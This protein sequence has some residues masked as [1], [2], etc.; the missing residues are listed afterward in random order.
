MNAPNPL[1]EPSMSRL[2]LI[3]VLF[4]LGSAGAQVQPQTPLKGTS[5]SR[6]IVELPGD[7]RMGK[8]TVCSE[9]E[10]LVPQL[11]VQLEQFTAGKAT[12]DARVQDLERLLRNVNTMAS[13]MDKRQAELAQSLNRVLGQLSQQPEAAA[14]RQIRRYS[15]DVEEV[16]EKA[17]RTATASGNKEAAAALKPAIEE[18][19]A[20]FD[21]T[22]AGKL[23]DAVAA[24]QE[25]L[26]DVDRKVDVVVGNT[27]DSRNMAVFVEALRSKSRGDLGQVRVL[28]VFVQQGRTFDNQ[29]FSGVGFPKAQVPGL[30]APGANLSLTTFP[31]ADLKGADLSGARMI[32]AVLEG[33]SLQGAK[34]P[35]ARAALVQAQ[36]ADLQGADLSRSNWI[37][38]DLRGANLRQANLKGASLAHADLRGADL[39]GADLTNTYLRNADLRDA[40]FIDTRFANTDVASALLQ[41]DQLSAPQFAGLCGTAGRKNANDHWMIIESIPS[42]VNDGGYKDRAIFDKSMWL[43]GGGHRPY[44]KCQLRPKT[45]MTDWNEPTYE[46]RGEESLSHS[47]D[48]GVEHL[49]MQAVG[50]RAELLDRMRSAFA[51]AEARPILLPTMQQHAQLRQRLYAA[52]NARQ[53]QLTARLTAP[54]RPLDF[55]P[56]TGTLLALR[57]RPA[58]LGELGISWSRAA[59]YGGSLGYEG[60]TPDDDHVW[61]RLFP[62]WL[63]NDDLSE[64]TSESWERWTRARSRVLS[65]N[66]T[67]LEL[68]RDVLRDGS[69]WE[70]VLVYQRSL[71][72][73]NPELAKRLGVPPDQ[74]VTYRR[75]D[76]LL[77]MTR[78]VSTGIVLNADVQTVRAAFKRGQ[79]PETGRLKLQV[80]VKDVR[81]VPAENHM[82]AHVV[83]TM[84]VQPL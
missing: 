79:T 51:A 11:K 5:C 47:F 57:V 15:D 49:L 56:D 31:G 42:S 73:S 38:A 45:L 3:V 7:S 33:A 82:D 44:P 35:R 27:D 30:V 26:G 78:E 63:M 54:P 61:P 40:K 21:L 29:D 83:W 25:K 50:R 43:G 32:A 67:V 80:V 2:F 60:S 17:E 76:S 70:R 58:L 77:G 48:F 28:G 72:A 20:T 69:T 71:G 68:S 22:K 75:V 36:G 10:R 39:S 19:M 14:A 52:L 13:R 53:Q 34:L 55:S 46:S 12:S 6:G 64:V 62:E 59:Q 24:L 74:L 84:E 81:Y 23:L 37:G 18:A 66:E 9:I 1:L 16:N 4:S 8:I 41:G 65:R